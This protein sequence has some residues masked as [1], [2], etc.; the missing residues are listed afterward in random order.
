M[1]KFTY[2]QVQESEMPQHLSNNGKEE[3]TTYKKLK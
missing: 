3:L 2:V 1:N